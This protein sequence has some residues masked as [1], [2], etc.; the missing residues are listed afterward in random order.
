MPPPPTYPCHSE[1]SRGI[2][3]YITSPLQT[4]LDTP[5]CVTHVIPSVAK[6][7]RPYIT[8]PP[9]SP[10]TPRQV[11]AIPQYPAAIPLARIPPKG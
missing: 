7:S 4:P 1:R 9:Q 11:Y 10:Q 5:H 2:S 3:P 8:S 6:E